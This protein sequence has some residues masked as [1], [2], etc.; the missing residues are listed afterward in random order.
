MSEIKNL[1]DAHPEDS[2]PPVAGFEP[3]SDSPRGQRPITRQ[4]PPEKQP[5]SV[6]YKDAPEQAKEKPEWGEGEAGYKRPKNAADKLRKN[7]PYKVSGRTSAAGM[8]SMFVYPRRHDRRFACSRAFFLTVSLPQ[9][10]GRFLNMSF[11]P[12]SPLWSQLFVCRSMDAGNTV[13]IVLNT[14]NVFHDAHVP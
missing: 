13:Y 11:K 3:S 8:M 7:T 10:L 12:G 14:T 1:K 5:P 6:K 9:E 4:T 2:D